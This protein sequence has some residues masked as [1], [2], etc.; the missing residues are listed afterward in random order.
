MLYQCDLVLER[1]YF[2]GEFVPHL[3]AEDDFDLD[4]PFTQ[5]KAKGGTMIM[6]NKKLSQFVTKLSSPCKSS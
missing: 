4:I 1:N 6:W 5:N 2:D 3:T